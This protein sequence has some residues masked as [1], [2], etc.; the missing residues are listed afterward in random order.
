MD[1]EPIGE[2]LYGRDFVDW[3]LNEIIQGELLFR[4]ADEAGVVLM[5]GGG[6]GDTHPS[7][8]V[9]L[10]NLNEYDY[11]AIGTAVRKLLDAY[12]ARFQQVHRG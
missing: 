5:P 3:L 7:A 12:Y 8:R 2:A 4:I 11:A 1:L 10:A 6:F 9:S